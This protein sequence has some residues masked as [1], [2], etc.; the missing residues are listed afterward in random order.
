MAEQGLASRP[1][2]SPAALRGGS[3]GVAWPD[4]TRI[5]AFSMIASKSCLDLACFFF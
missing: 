4:R 5:E 2:M 3:R 1:G